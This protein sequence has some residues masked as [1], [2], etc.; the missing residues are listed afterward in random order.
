MQHK[1]QNA[2]ANLRDVNFFPSI[3]GLQGSAVLSGFKGLDDKAD[4]RP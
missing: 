2:N 1:V 3:K 4:T